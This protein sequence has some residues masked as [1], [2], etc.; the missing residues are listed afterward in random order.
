MVVQI[1]IA[2]VLTAGATLAGAVLAQSWRLR[3]IARAIASDGLDLPPERPALVGARAR[4]EA[5]Y[6]EHRRSRVPLVAWTPG[7]IGELRVTGEDVRFLDAGTLLHHIPL[8]R[9]VEPK[10]LP[11]FGDLAA[12]VVGGILQVDWLRGGHRV[13]SVFAIDGTRKTA[14]SIRREIH[15]RAGQAPLPVP[16]MPTSV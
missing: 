8:A 13:T 1:A 5:T 7:V 9:V 3:R 2:A 11:R 6:F 14:E 16:A 12:D 4:H 10:L 15:L